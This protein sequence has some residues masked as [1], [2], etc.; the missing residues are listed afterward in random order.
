MY[1]PDAMEFR[2]VN[3]VASG[4]D[5]MQRIAG[6]DADQLNAVVVLFTNGRHA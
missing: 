5:D 6:T 1:L 3:D 2:R 4:H